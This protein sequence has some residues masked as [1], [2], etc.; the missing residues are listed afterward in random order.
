[1]V[2]AMRS[3]LIGYVA[4]LWGGAVVGYGLTKGLD[5]TTGAYAAG[6]IAGLALGVVLFLTGSWILVRRA[7]TSV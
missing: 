7:R 1:M 3:L 2:C 5:D 6:S 4:V